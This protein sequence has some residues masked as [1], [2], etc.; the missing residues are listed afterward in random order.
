MERR[1]GFYLPR[2]NVLKV[3]APIA[4]HMLRRGA[5]ALRPVFL[6]PGWRISKAQRQPRADAVRLAFGGQVEVIRL[7]D[8]DALER[9]IAS[10]SLDAFVNL[11]PTVCEID[12]TA[13]RRLREISRRVGTIWI[14]LPYTFASEEM[15]LEDPALALELWDRVCLIGRRSVEY[16]ELRLRAASSPLRAPLLARTAITGYP[17]LDG[18]SMLDDERAIRRKYGLPLD[19]PIIV[20]ATAPSFYPLIRR[21]RT[22]Q[23]LEMRF[24]GAWPR[25][26]GGAA[27]WAASA[28]RY[29]RVA[30]YRRYLRAL[31]AFADANGACLVAKTR[32]KHRDPRYVRDM[33]DSIVGDDSFFP[34]TTLELLRVARLYVGFYSAMT[35]EAVAAGVYAISALFMPPPAINRSPADRMRAEFFHRNPGSLWNA[36]GVSELID[37][38]TRAGAAALER[39]A[40]ARF[41]AYAV[42]ERQRAALLERYVSHLGRSSQRVVE[43]LEE[44]WATVRKAAVIGCNP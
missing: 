3:M 30:S 34:F 18:L 43:V 29:P 20:V 23:G 10:G 7:D 6:V 39:L 5:G 27:A 40:H 4:Q 32:D 44:S 11:T 41:E 26:P 1:V 19:R 8:I 17:E 9:L 36:P 24:R 14:A 33:V 12:L 28:W 13:L 16:L 21:S 31:R 37:G 15:I 42:D 25:S 22:L 2:D 38:T 35:L